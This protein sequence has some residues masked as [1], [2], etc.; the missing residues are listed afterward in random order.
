MAKKKKLE[1]MS[2]EELWEL[3]PIVI[4]PPNPEW[5]KWAN[6]E[7]KELKNILGELITQINHIGSTAI[8]GIWAKPIIDILIE[9]DSFST[10][11]NIKAKLLADGYI[12]MNESGNRIDFNK[13]YTSKGFAEKVFHLHLRLTGDNNEIY[14]RDYLNFNREVA[15]E[16]EKLKLSI[17]KQYEHDRDGYTEAKTYFINFYTSLAISHFKNNN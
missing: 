7:M 15:E 8:K 2:L 1:E 4:T 6:K 17:W 11:S 10:M 16:Y 13:G 14:F 5:E 3:F 12:C 9:T